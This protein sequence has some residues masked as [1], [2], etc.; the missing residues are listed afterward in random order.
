MPNFSSLLSHLPSLYDFLNQRYLSSTSTVLRLHPPSPKTFSVF[1]EDSNVFLSVAATTPHEFIIS[2]DFNIH[3]D[4]PTEHFSSQFLS[5]LS[6]FNL[7]Q[8]VSFHTHDKNHIRVLVI[9]STD[10]ALAPAGSLTHLFCCL[11]AHVKI[12]SRIVSYRT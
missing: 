5:L 9:N 11:R 2:G 1:L 12:A 7:A 6:S 4:N 8:H 3:L 10:I